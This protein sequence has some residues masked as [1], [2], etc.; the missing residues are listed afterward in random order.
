MLEHGREYLTFKNKPFWER[1]LQ[2]CS[3]FSSLHPTQ[4]SS[5]RF[6]M[7]YYADLG[8][9]LSNLEAGQGTAESLL[10]QLFN[11]LG[12]TMVLLSISPMCRF[13]THCPQPAISTP[14][15]D[16]FGVGPFPLRPISQHIRRFRG[17]P[18]GHFTIPLHSAQRN[19]R[20]FMT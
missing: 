6:G 15:P 8:G 20:G 4:T 14:H 5:T 17:P 16:I 7:E 13:Q 2:G 18:P 9:N 11:H 3:D 12:G 10:Q 1:M 19:I